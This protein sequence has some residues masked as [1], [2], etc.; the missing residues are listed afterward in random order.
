VEAVI[1]ILGAG[2]HGHQLAELI[3]N[4]D[5]LMFDDHLPGYRKN[6]EGA[7][8]YPWLVGAAWPKVRRQIVEAI[9]SQIYATAPPWNRG[10]VIYPGCRIGTGVK[11]G[12][13]VHAQFNSVISHGCRIGDFV[14][15]CPG[16]VLSGE[17]TVEDDVFLG[18]NSTVIHGGIT[19]GKGATVG[20]GAVVIDDVPPGA[21]VVGVPAKVIKL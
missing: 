20:A 11:I 3:G 4:V 2:P 10:N 7:R 1:A 6:I 5:T 8:S 9:S 19:I 16:V 13:H 15:I 14:T 12:R 21:T 17:V 18:A